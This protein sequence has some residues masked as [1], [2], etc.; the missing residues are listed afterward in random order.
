MNVR[1]DKK[2]NQKFSISILTSDDYTQ[3]LDY[4]K[5]NDFHVSYGIYIRACNICI[6][7][8]VTDIIRHIPSLHQGT[9]F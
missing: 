4:N 9:S 8:V 2:K 5:I 6:W 3:T 7:G 1:I